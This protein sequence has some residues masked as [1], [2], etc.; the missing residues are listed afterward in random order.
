MPNDEY[1]PYHQ[2]SSEGNEI[3]G[4]SWQMVHPRTENINQSAVSTT[5]GSDEIVLCC[6]SSTAVVT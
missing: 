4:C 5:L 1:D 6:S 2:S 3:S